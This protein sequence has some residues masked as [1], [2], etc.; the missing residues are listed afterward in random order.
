MKVLFLGDTHGNI[1]WLNAIYETAAGNGI[2]RIFVVGDFGYWEHEE[3]GIAFLDVL[4]E[5]AVESG[6]DL[7]W[8][9]GNHENHRLLRE[10]YTER[11]EEGF[12]PIREN[13]FYAPRGQRW[14][15][16]GVRFLAL[17]GAAS[18]DKAYRTEGISWWPEEELTQAEI[19]PILANDEPVDIMLTHDKPL[20]ADPKWG[21]PVFEFLL[22]NQ[23][24]IQQVMDVVK[25]TLLIHGHL[26]YRYNDCMVR[27]G[28][29]TNVVALAHDG[30]YFPDTHMVIDLANQPGRDGETYE[31]NDYTG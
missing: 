13:I 28:Y 8:L 11:N 3:E 29:V 22:P 19:D 30:E 1:R 6:I 15:W 9:D 17:G 18:I 31:Y 4:Q 2:D 12:I 27:D 23:E 16:D 5:L 7:Y 26:H 14:T 21:R 20:F 10:K 24:K 25:P